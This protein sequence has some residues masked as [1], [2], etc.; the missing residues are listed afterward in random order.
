M[1]TLYRGVETTLLLFALALGAAALAAS[2]ILPPNHA[3]PE[4]VTLPM[5]T[6][7]AEGAAPPAR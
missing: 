3:A 2:A 1:D 7:V 6:V 5:L 4:A